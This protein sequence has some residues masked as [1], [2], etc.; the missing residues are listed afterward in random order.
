V[1]LTLEDVDSKVLDVRL[2]SALDLAV[3]KIARFDSHDRKLIT[4][5]ALR[6]R[7]EDALVAYVGDKA[8]VRTSIDMAYRIVRDVEQRNR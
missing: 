1:Q 2:L 7:A 4:S 8:R 6:R 3:S 5:T